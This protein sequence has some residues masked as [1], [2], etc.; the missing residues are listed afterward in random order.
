MRVLWRAGTA[1]L[2]LG[3]ALLAGAALLDPPHTPPLYDGANAPDEPYRYVSPPAGYR[4]T[5]APTTASR[6]VPVTNGTIAETTFFTGEQ[7]PQ[8]L[9]FVRTLVISSGAQKLNLSITP[10]ALTVP[11]PA[12]GTILSNVY[13]L[14]ATDDQG[15]PVG[16]AGQANAAFVQMRIP[17]ATRAAV[18]GEVYA[19]GRWQDLRTLPAGNDVYG[20]SLTSF[21]LVAMVLVT[22]PGANPGVVQTKRSS[23]NTALLAGLGLLAGVVIV[24]TVGVV[25]LRRQ[26]AAARTTG[27]KAPG[28]GRPLAAPGARRGR[29]GK[30]RSRPGGRSTTRR[31]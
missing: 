18:V 14:G 2:A 8:A 7:A 17:Q 15:R 5:P 30:G 19:D 28:G 4:H 24:G 16:I 9:L 13:R 29:P 23:N 10:V 6:S 3:A 31:G 12:D 21:G 25:R 26:R 22:H 11:E 1:T 27:R 20:A